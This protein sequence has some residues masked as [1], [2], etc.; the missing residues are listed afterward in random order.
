MDS[1]VTK[2]IT[3]SKEVF[4]TLFEWNSKFQ[5][6]VGRQE[7]VGDLR[8][9]CCAIQDGDKMHDAGPRCTICTRTRI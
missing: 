8:I 1:G 4:E 2:H 9:R 6:G 3:G 7:S 5:H